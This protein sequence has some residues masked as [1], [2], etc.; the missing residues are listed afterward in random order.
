MDLQRVRGYGVLR[1]SG[2]E[3]DRVHKA[4]TATGAGKCAPNFARIPPEYVAV[5]WR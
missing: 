4:A 3:Q 2:K 5:R 1:L